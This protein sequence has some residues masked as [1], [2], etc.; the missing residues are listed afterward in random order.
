M[1]RFVTI[2]ALVALTLVFAGGSWADEIPSGATEGTKLPI[3]EG[4]DLSEK[5][6]DLSAIMG[7]KTVV[8]SFWSI[9]CSD[10]IRELDDLRSIRA[11][12]PIEE[13]EVV[14]VNT[15]SAMPVARIASFV[16]RYEDARGTPLNVIHLLDRSDKIVDQLGIQYIPLMITVDSAGTVSSVVSG[17]DHEEDR[18]RLFQVLEQ[19]RLSVGTW[20]QRLRGK[21]RSILRGAG[22]GGQP[23]E[24]GSF[25]VEEGMSLF[26]LHDGDEWLLDATMGSNREA[27][28]NRVVDVVD[29]KLKVLLMKN[30]LTSIGVKLPLIQ[31][32][33]FGQKGIVIPEGPFDSENNLGKLYEKIG[34][35]NLYQVE[36][37]TGHWFGDEYWGALV[38]DVDLGHL[39]AVLKELGFPRE[40]LK[41]RIITVSDYDYKPRAFLREFKKR[42]YRVHNFDNSTVEYYGT[43]DMLVEEL[44][45]ITLDRVGVFVEKEEAA[46]TVRV[47]FF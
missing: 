41:I 3:L 35:S 37:R 11:E 31:S 36:A 1:K 14:A 44:Q 7:K 28:T 15:D 38:G 45:K 5:P 46:D 8:L 43:V 4:I 23:V 25:R 33:S 24:W 39:R 9:Y 13:V 6:M 10:C 30:A 17:Y 12:F 16:R 34:F 21:V 32:A 47:E 2:A 26:G 19:G 22:P 42:S 27:E 18:G 20:G 40:P 29:Q